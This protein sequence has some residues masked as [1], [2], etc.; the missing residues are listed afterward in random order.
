MKIDKAGE[1]LDIRLMDNII[2]A[3]GSGDLFS[4]KENGLMEDISR[5]TRSNC[6]ER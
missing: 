2:I 4:F 3:G 5:G 6:L 1:I